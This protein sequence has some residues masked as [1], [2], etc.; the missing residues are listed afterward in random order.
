[1]NEE[2]AWDHKVDATMVE[3]PI[4]KVSRKKVRKAIRNKRKAAGLCEITT[5]MSVARGRIAEEVMLQL[6]QRVLN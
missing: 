2:S 1:M 5:E 3:G 4:E 6:C